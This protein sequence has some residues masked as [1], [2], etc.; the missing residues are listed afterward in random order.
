MASKSTVKI[1]C[2]QCNLPFWSEEQLKKHAVTHKR[3]KSFNCTHCQKGFVR[4]N[5]LKMHE[6]TCEKNPEKTNEVRKT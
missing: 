3:R 4:G 1:R 5:R 6:R 2:Q